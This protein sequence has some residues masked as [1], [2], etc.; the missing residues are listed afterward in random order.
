MIDVNAYCKEMPSVTIA[1]AI[2]Q[3]GS[4][5][6]LGRKVRNAAAVLDRYGIGIV[7][8]NLIDFNKNL[9]QDIKKAYKRGLISVLRN[10]TEVDFLENLQELFRMAGLLPDHR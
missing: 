2:K 5:R 3:I 4:C 1:G 9:E 8:D 7:V 10:S 6:Q